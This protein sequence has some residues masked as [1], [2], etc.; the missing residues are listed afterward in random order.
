MSEIQGY[1]YLHE[2]GDLIYKNG[3]DAILDIRDSDLCHS[4][5]AWT[6]ERQCA[7]QI[8]VESLSL[9]EN[10]RGTE[11]AKRLKA[12]VNELAEKWGL[13]DSDAEQYAEFIGIK[14]GI[15]G[16]QKTATKTDF[17]NLQES[18][19]GFGDSNLYAMASLCHELEYRGGKMWN[20]TFQDLLNQ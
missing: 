8:C 16:N 10:L 19:C 12:R 14:L 5:W 11:E 4:A 17:I 6:G 3:S 9:I 2:N 1:Y 20:T 18:P 15:D 7:W 13:T